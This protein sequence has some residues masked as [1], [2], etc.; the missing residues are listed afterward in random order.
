MLLIRVGSYSATRKPWS[1]N[2]LTSVSIVLAFLLP[3]VPAA[4]NGGGRKGLAGYEMCRVVPGTR[5][6]G[7]AFR[8]CIS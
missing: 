3:G 1:G 8:N 4:L 5:S 7:G 6:L 2:A